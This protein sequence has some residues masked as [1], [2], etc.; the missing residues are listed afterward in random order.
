LP[1]SI[2]L[3]RSA[4]MAKEPTAEATTP[5]KMLYAFWPQ[6]DVRVDAG[7]IIDLPISKAKELIAAGK[8]ERADAFPGEA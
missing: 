5:I 1:R 4:P 6:E 3:H 7:A 8:A 2:T